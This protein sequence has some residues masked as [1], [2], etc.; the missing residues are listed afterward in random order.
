MSREPGRFAVL[1]AACAVAAGVLAG[2]SPAAEI[3]ANDDTAKYVTDGGA[4]FY[5]Q[6]AA[7]GLR[8]SVLTVRFKP[9]EPTRIP[10]QTA[11]DAAVAQAR[12]AGLAVVFS[13]Y[14]YPPRELA[15]G[16]GSPTAFAAWLE[17]LAR[18]YPQVRQ[19]VV[20]NEPNQTAFVRPQFGRNRRNV[21]AATAGAYLA[22]GYDALRAVDP[23]ITV[24]GVGLSPRGND[25]PHATSNPSVSPL[26]FLA[27]LGRWYRASGRTK[28]LMDGFSFH[29]Y[30]RSATDTLAQGYMWPNAGFVNLD[31]V[32]QGLWDAFHGTAQPTTVDGLDLYLDEV[33]WQ[34]GTS[35][36][37]GYSGAENVSVTT[38]AAQAAIYRDLVH[39]AACDRSVAEVN[40]FGFY[41]DPRRSGFQAG[42]YHAD[43]TPRPSAEAVQQAVSETTLTGCGGVPAAWVP[44]PGVVGAQMQPGAP[45]PTPVAANLPVSFAIRADVAEGARITAFVRRS[46]QPSSVLSSL[47][48][49]PEPTLAPPVVATVVTPYGHA[50]LTIA[51]P[52][53]LATGT[54]EVAVRFVA[55]A[56]SRRTTLIRGPTFRVTASP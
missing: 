29:P 51:L 41:D 3:G 46:S 52:G 11:L 5:R 40:F 39:L 8:Q 56:N 10:G 55:E 16:K 24:V 44:S 15:A 38:E 23:R 33:G 35:G 1:A 45:A 25:D 28:P 42:L 13:V 6:M 9:S 50:N 43:G 34:V 20:G 26:R 37:A 12:A 7:L 17:I 54:Y 53:G 2:V 27:A 48:G 49:G 18:R 36:A 4:V 19:Y 14:P 32:K 21:S 47:L 30:P 31:R 22:A